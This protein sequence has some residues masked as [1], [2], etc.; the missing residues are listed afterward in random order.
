MPPQITCAS[1][2][3]DKTGKH[4]NC[5]FHSYAVLVHCR[6]QPAA[7]FLQFFWLTTPIHVAVRLRKSCN[8]CVQLG[9]VGGMVQE[10]GTWERC[11]SWT[12]LLAQCTSA[13][14][15]GFPV[16][17]GN[18]KAL[19]RWCGK[20]KHRLISYFLSNTSAKNCCN[21]IMYVKI[22]VSRGSEAGLLERW[23]IV[24]NT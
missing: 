11:S 13:L 10:K 14:L 2:L 21:L 6:I 1:A 4:K 5:I 17:Q 20:T 16:S 8:Q 3:P 12:L 15:L 24:V 19:D 23:C 22:I 9:P 18:A 7:W